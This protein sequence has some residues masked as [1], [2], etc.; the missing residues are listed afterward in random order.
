MT[1]NIQQRI[2]MLVTTSFIAIHAMIPPCT[3]E[4][5]HYFRRFLFQRYDE[6][7]FSSTVETG[8]F[9]AEFTVIAA[10]AS[11]LYLAAG[12]FPDSEQLPSRTD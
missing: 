9:L 2:I 5:G 7:G 11:F 10:A 3:R 8:Q 12:L 4:G 6:H 1:M